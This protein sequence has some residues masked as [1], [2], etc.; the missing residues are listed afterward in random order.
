MAMGSDPDTLFDCIAQRVL[1]KRMGE[2][3]PGVKRPFLGRRLRRIGTGIDILAAERYVG[4]ILEE[5][6]LE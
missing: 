1:L 4:E 3:K 2:L 5:H 6:G